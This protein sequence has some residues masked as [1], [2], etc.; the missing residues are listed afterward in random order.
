M[1]YYTT[2]TGKLFC[3]FPALTFNG[4]SLPLSHHSLPFTLYTQT[5]T[6]CAVRYK[7]NNFPVTTHITAARAKYNARGYREA[8]PS[9]LQ[10]NRVMPVG[11]NLAGDEP[12]MWLLNRGDL[13]E[14]S[15]RVA[16]EL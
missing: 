13:L 16:A 4:P 15:F 3:L 2:R 12:G 5:C 11:A 9:F 1:N 8:W 14:Q 6:P 10:D 7:K